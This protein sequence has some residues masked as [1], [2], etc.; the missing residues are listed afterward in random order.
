MSPGTC[1][2]KGT[3][4]YVKSC[5]ICNQNK[6][7]HV[8]PRAALRS[9]HAGFPM[10]RV[11]LDILGPFNTRESGNRYILMMVDQ[12]TKWVEMAAIPEQPALLIAQKFVVHFIT[13]LDVHSRFIQTRVEILMVLYSVHCVKLWRSQRQGPLPTTLPPMGRYNALAP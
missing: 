10:E 7:P 11:H 2:P 9:F 12:F 1:L 8:K 3:C 5:G 6:K 13:T 4:L